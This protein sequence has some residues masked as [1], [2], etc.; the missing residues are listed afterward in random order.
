MAKKAIIFDL[1]GVLALNGWQ[2]FKA[3]HFHDREHIWDAVYELGK[4]VDAGLADYVELVRF[5]ARQTGETEETVR[6]QL[7]HTLA[8]DELLA[9]IQTVLEP[10]YK[11]GIVS[12]GGNDKVLGRFTAAQR[13]LFQAVVFSRD[14]GFLKPQ[15]DIYQIVADRL[16]VSLSDCIFVDDHK[17]HVDGAKREG[18]QVVR[19]TNLSRLKRELAALL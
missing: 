16:G 13:N 2:A 8:N 17:S 12:N 10:H 15:R 19:Y 1:Y 14:V 9:Y 7:E 5:T 18:L 6:Y 11:L 3:K 4:R